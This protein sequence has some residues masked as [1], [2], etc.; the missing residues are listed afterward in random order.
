[1]S[2]VFQKSVIEILIQL[3]RT[4]CLFQTFKEIKKNKKLLVVHRRV[5]QSIVFL[6]TLL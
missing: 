2:N 6:P 5:R 1:M 3:I 4:L